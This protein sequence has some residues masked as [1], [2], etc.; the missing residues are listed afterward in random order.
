MWVI[1]VNRNISQQRDSRIENLF[2]NSTVP[3]DYLTKRSGSIKYSTTSFIGGALIFK[4]ESGAARLINNFNYDTQKHFSQ[5]KFYWINSYVLSLKKLT[6][7][8]WDMIMNSELSTLERKYVK[9]K[10]KLLKKKSLY[11]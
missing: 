11:K 3:Q 9:Q 7:D 8:E 10:E 2:G 6:K 5:N 4:T 1:V